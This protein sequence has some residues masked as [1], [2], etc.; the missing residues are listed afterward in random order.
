YCRY[1]EPAKDE[2]Y[3]ATNYFQKVFY[4]RLGTPQA[5]DELT[6]FR[7]DQKEWVY[8]AVVSEDGRYL[9]IHVWN[10]TSVNN[11][12]FYRD[13]ESG[14][15]IVDLIPKFDSRYHFVAN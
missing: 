8:D 4:H 9:I 7:A 10:A 11:A 1:D 14:G 15:P 13:L 3:E 5:E 2:E 12:V 6:Y